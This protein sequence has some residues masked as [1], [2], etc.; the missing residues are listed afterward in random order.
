MPNRSNA[1]HRAVRVDGE[2]RHAVLAHELLEVGPDRVGP[3][4]QHVGLLVEHLVEDL[5][6]LVGQ[7]HLVR[8]RVHQRPADGGGVPVLHHRAQLAADVLDRLAHQRQ[9]LLQARL[10]DWSFTGIAASL[11]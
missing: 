5:H 11:V 1:P 9:Q 6:A 10:E 8:V 7:A 3:L 2:L 4:G